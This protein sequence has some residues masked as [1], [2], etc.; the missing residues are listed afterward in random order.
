MEA[1]QF[2]TDDPHKAFQV[3]PG[4]GPNIAQDFAD[5][6]FVRVSNLRGQD[7]LQLYHDLSALRGTHVDRCVLYVF[8]LAVYFAEN[9]VRE[10]ELLKWWNWKDRPNQT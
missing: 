1:V 8:R 3:I 2:K 4:V 6:G 7:S 9:D 10:P 5:L